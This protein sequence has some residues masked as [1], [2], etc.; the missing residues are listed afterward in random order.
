M[1]AQTQPKLRA[2]LRVPEELVFC[3][4]GGKEVCTP[5]SGCKIV[6]I[7]R[8]FKL[9]DVTSDLPEG[10]RELEGT[11]DE[12]CVRKVELPK[13]VI[14]DPMDVLALLQAE[15][16]YRTSLGG[17]DAHNA[18][19]RMYFDWWE[20]KLKNSGTD[21]LPKDVVAVGST[22]EDVL[23]EVY[24][25]GLKRAAEELKKKGITTIK[26]RELESVWEAVERYLEDV[27]AEDADL[28]DLITAA[29]SISYHLDLDDEVGFADEGIEIV[30]EDDEDEDEQK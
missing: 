22:F 23:L 18:I 6:P 1:Q 19:T 27:I 29:Q 7:E 5:T 15:E 26:R 12:E 20:E 3:F 9:V 8:C 28:Y 11:Y 13:Y 30:E 10:C 16:H 4:Y 17:W 21:Q 24:E 25:K 2:A 14:V